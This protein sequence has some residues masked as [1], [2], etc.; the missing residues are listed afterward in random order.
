MSKRTQKT[1]AMT[2]LDGAHKS[3]LNGDTIRLISPLTREEM[4]NQM[5][6]IFEKQH[7]K[8]GR[9]KNSMVVIDIGANM[10]LSAIYFQDKSKMIYAIEPSAKHYTALVENTKQ[11]PNIKCF[12]LAITDY[13]GEIELFSNDDGIIP[14]SIYGSGKTKETVQCMRL[15][16]FM[17]MNSI[18]KV[19]LL[20][21]D[22]EG[23]EYRIFLA[24]DFKEIASK[25]N[26]IVGE[27]HFFNIFVPDYIRPILAELGFKC[28]FIKDS[29]NMWKELTITSPI[30][31]S[32]RKFRVYFDTLFVAIRK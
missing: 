16:T 7:Y 32:V 18:K 12:N 28:R 19:D 14:E 21:I 26:R 11:F 22:C 17:Q 3:I 9:Y 10:G 2:F 23:S 30:D 24:P 8:H 1:V 13:E 15:S 29:Q 31:A 5:S 4:S 25:I 20:K 6:E 27:A